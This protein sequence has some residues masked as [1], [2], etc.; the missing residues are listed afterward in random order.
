MTQD[1]F[2]AA[3]L[4]VPFPLGFREFPAS[5]TMSAR[6][7]TPSFARAAGRLQL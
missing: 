4:F 3:I 6:R 2:T 7:A 5:A 1:S